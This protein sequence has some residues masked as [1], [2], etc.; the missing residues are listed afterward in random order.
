MNNK[1]LIKKDSQE[2]NQ[3]YTFIPNTGKVTKMVVKERAQGYLNEPNP[4]SIADK[5]NDKNFGMQQSI[6]S[7]QFEKQ[8]RRINEEKY[9][10]FVLNDSNGFLPSQPKQ[11][12][13]NY[14]SISSDRYKNP[15]SNSDN[16]YHINAE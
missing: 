3:L 10:T 8:K 9:C 12:R 16:S 6:S 5:Q 14:K 7:S 4:Y 15:M 1:F 11:A 13:S 2:T